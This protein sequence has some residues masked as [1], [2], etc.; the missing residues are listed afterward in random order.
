MRLRSLAA[1]VR[2]KSPSDEGSLVT[3]SCFEH[4]T[5]PLAPHELEWRDVVDS[6]AGTSCWNHDTFQCERI[7][8][9][10]GDYSEFSLPRL[11]DKLVVGRSE[12]RIYRVQREALC[13]IVCPQTQL[14]EKRCSRRIGREEK[15]TRN[16]SCPWNELV[17]S[18][19]DFCAN[20]IN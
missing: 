1:R 10:V 2:A 4:E 19:H 11:S 18:A 5:K 14:N 3:C 7:G 6:E 16:S 20:G 13:W 12:E 15:F 9:L 17:V 8:T